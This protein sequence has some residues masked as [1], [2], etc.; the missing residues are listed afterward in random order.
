MSYL[1]DTPVLAELRRRAPDAEVLRW[2]AKR[3]ANTLYLSVLTLG[4]LKKGIET[5]AEG[6]RKQTLLDWL[7]AE[8]PKFF[9]GRLLPIDAPV[10]Q[11]W[12]RL[13]ALAG[14]PLPTIDSWLAATALTHNLTL[15][16]RSRKD[17]HWPELQVIDPW[18][19]QQ[20]V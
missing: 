2:F 7:E 16:T 10:A 17:F 20:S 4:E 5:L 15:V 13:L 14:R 8:L 1:I 11:C 18:I 19:S 3:P 9:A 6:A 12:G